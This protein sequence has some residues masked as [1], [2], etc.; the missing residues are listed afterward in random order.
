MFQSCKTITAMALLLG[1]SGAASANDLL[2]LANRYTVQISSAVEYPFGEER[3]GTSRGAG[4]LI[5]RERGWILTN[6]HVARRAPA[7]IRVNFKGGSVKPAER[8]Y[9]DTHL[10][11][12]ILKLDPAGIPDSALVASTACASEASAGNPVIAFGHPWGLDYT[13][14]R[15]IVSGAKSIGGVEHL[16]TDAA[17]N[18]GNSGG[19]LIDE[20]SGVVVGVNVSTLSKSQTEGMN[21]AVPIKLVCTILSLL[22]EGKDPSPPLSPVKFAETLRDREL[23]IGE[24][25]GDWASALRTGD[26]IL[27]VNGD[28]SAR[29]VS[30]FLD[31]IRGKDSVLIKIER[32]GKAQEVKLTI[33]PERDRLRQMGVYMSGMLLSGPVQM[34][35]DKKSISVQYIE[36]ASLAEEGRLRIGDII[37]SIDGK[38]VNSYEDLVAAIRGKEGKELSFIVKRERLRAR[39]RHEYFA[40]R[41]EMDKAVFVDEKGLRAG[42]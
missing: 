21:F 12:A 2:D 26:R 16:Q 4:F 34:D 13:A 39:E 11:I 23:L 29:Y 28:Q 5:D 19:P 36:R 32:E 38:T 1:A 8:I 22:K 40:R 41:V 42:E 24:V 20:R 37:A 9:I 6:A 15:G 30:R 18:P 14:T 27:A 35:E 17:L 31:H 25:S 33:P 7:K 3:K 10:D